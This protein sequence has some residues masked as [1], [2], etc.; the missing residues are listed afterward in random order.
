MTIEEKIEELYN[1]S[2]QLNNEHKIIDIGFVD[3]KLAERILNFT[4]LDLC[5]FVI[6]MDNYGI[7][8]SLEKHGNPI[9]EVMRGQLNVT[10]E[11]F[12][13]I[14]LILSEFDSVRHDIKYTKNSNISRESLVFEKK[15]GN[16]FFVAKEIRKIVKADKSNRLVFHTLYIR[17]TTSDLEIKSG[18]L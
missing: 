3:D 13:L 12:K 17:K 14:P 6:S 10:K 11:D 16:R 8:H 1:Y 4:G 2:L 7:I 5:G 9:T 15:I 18:L